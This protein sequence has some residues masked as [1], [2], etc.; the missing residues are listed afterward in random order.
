MLADLNIAHELVI[1]N[2]NAADEFDRQPSSQPSVLP[3]RSVSR[4]AA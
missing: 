2:L 1:F 4:Y 3:V